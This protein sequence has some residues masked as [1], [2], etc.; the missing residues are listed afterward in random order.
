MEKKFLIE[1]IDKN[2]SIN[3]ISKLGGKSKTTVRYWLSKYGL[4]TT[5]KSF[6]DGGS[7]TEY[8]NGKNCPRCKEIKPTD[9]FYQ[10]RG[11]QGGSVYCKTCSSDQSI[12]RQRELKQKAINYKGGACQKCGYNRCNAALEFHHINPNEKDFSISNLKSYAFNDKIKMELDKCIMLCANCH[13][14]VH[15]RLINF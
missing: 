9:E 14:E 3:Q 7:K 13:R 11:K 15:A 6:K 4:N 2:L 12:E 10:R 1:C 5:H 8:P